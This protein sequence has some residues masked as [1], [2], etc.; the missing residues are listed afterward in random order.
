MKRL[1][2]LFAI[3]T[4]CTFALWAQDNT[5][6]SSTTTQDNSGN[7]TTSKTT[8]TTTRDDNGSSQATST[9]PTTADQKE[10]DKARARSAEDA[11]D[12]EK[13][14][15]K[16][17][18]SGVAEERDKA[19]ARLDESSKV[20]DQ[21]LAAGDSGIPTS[22]FDKAKC[23]AVV[24]SMVRGGFI[25]GAE[26]GRGVASCRTPKGWS[27]PALF[28][29]TGGTWGAQ[30]GGQAVDLVMLFMT[31]EGAKHLLNAKVNIGADVSAAAGPV[32]RQASA[33]TDW[34]FDTGIL[35]YSRSRGLF[36][37]AILKGASVHQ[38]DKATQ[39]VYGTQVG[40]R[41]ILSGQ[42]PSPRTDAAQ[43]FLATVNRAHREAAAAH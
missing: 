2:I 21:L 4:L 43:R 36:A 6:S 8:T 24:P 35:T 32:G 3:L 22:V 19:Y 26:H 30:I 33:N 14:A 23:V 15:A 10:A 29:L 28:T 42:V 1:G 31:D 9:S 13:D 40:F 39:A 34:K 5:S 12:R 16:N 27:A 20:L 17:A 18:P 7:T 37:G 25:F 41:Q 38:D 11:A